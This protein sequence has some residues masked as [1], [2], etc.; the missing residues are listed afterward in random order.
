MGRL[1]LGSR[2]LVPLSP[3]TRYSRYTVP[4]EA[5]VFRASPVMMRSES[6]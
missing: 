1:M 5:M 4:P 3:H 2:R 6:L